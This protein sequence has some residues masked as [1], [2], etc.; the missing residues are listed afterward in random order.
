MM[1]DSLRN[2]PKNAVAI[3]FNTDSNLNGQTTLASVT[4]NLQP[5]GEYCRWLSA[6]SQREIIRG[7]LTSTQ[8]NTTLKASNGRPGEKRFLVNSVWWRKWCDFVN[9]DLV[10]AEQPST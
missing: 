9:F 1:P 2:T 10:E 5:C 4:G 3:D 8:G 7:I 6:E